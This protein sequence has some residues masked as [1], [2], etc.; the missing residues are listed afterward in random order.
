MKQICVFIFFLMLTSCEYFN[1]KKTSSEA[2]LKEELQTFNW[3]EVDEYPTFSICDSVSV[4][5]K[6][7]D[8]FVEVLT[9]HISE[10]LQKETIIISQDINDTI[11]LKL[12]VSEK[13][14]LTLLN[15]TIDSLTIQEIPII[16]NLLAESLNSLPKI[17]PAIKRGQQVKTEFKLPIIIHV[18]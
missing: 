15:T 13:G 6:R 14:N 11:H 12:Q 7:S 2:I 3:S 18:N 16:K 4:K 1:V 8:C 10:F 5:Q 9:T 17:F